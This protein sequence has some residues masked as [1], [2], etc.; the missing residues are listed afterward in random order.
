VL[1]LLAPC[2]VVSEIPVPERFL[3]VT[4]GVFLTTGSSLPLAETST[5]GSLVAPEVPPAPAGEL[6]V[7]I[8]L[9]GSSFF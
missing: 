9:E 5:T 1:E 4:S 7:E 3:D 2:S 6:T 8:H